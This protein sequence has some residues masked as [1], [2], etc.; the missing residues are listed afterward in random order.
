M[1]K[2]SS[3]FP[4]Q[5]LYRFSEQS[6]K[7]LENF[8]ERYAECTFSPISFQEGSVTVWAGISSEVR[9][10]LYIVPRETLTVDRYINEILQDYDVPMYLLETISHFT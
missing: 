7:N 4:V 6:Q 5:I 3:K 10:E 8:G 1:L 9:K 2:D